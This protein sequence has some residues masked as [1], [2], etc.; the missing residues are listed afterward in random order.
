MQ[1][2][3]SWSQSP[4]SLAPVR[5]C[6]NLGSLYD[7]TT[8]STTGPAS[9]NQSW[10]TN[11]SKQSSLHNLNISKQCQHG[12]PKNLDSILTN[13][14]LNRW[15]LIHWSTDPPSL[16]SSF[17]NPS[18]KISSQ[19]H[20]NIIPMSTQCLPINIYPTSTARRC[21]PGWCRWA[22]FLPAKRVASPRRAPKCCFPVA[23]WWIPPAWCGNG[24]QRI[25]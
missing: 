21:P 1:S 4:P 10:Q 17:E 3:S 15:Q 8:W 19:D 9:T 7:R 20:P 6:C 13:L 5:M 25:Q 16:A 12:H 18:T 24:I 14:E 22:T 2:D 11:N 23:P